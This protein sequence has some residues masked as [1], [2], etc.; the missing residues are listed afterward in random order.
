MRLQILYIDGQEQRLGHEIQRVI[1]VVAVIPEGGD[2]C[3]GLAADL[4][5]DVQ[6]CSRFINARIAHE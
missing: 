6:R 2:G 1:V 3:Q 4:V 5:I